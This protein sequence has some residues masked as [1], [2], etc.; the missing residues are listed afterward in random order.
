MTSFEICYYPLA[1][2]LVFLY[3]CW[4]GGVWKALFA[5][6]FSVSGVYL[7]NRGAPA[8]LYVGGRVLLTHP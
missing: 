6:V 5:A 2:L 7:L 4:Y 3:V 8:L 1:A